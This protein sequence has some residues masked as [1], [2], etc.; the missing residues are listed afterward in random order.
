MA[1]DRPVDA[2]AKAAGMVADDGHTR[3]GK[4]EPVHGL[5]G[6]PAAYASEKPQGALDHF[7]YWLTNVL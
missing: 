3:W 7:R 4:P 2:V 5:N 6:L 1:G